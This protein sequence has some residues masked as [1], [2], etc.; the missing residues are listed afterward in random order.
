MEI[1]SWLLNSRERRVVPEDG[2]TVVA[3]PPLGLPAFTVPKA[4]SGI[5]FVDTA[6]TWPSI[7]DEPAALVACNTFIQA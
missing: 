4:C 5:G 1:F 7:L 6:N 3:H 2:T